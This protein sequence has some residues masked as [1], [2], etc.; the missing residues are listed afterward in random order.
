M[1]RDLHYPCA[2]NH[3]CNET[4]VF[5]ALSGM[6]LVV[7]PFTRFH[8]SNIGTALLGHCLARAANLSYADLLQQ[9]YLTPIHMDGTMKIDN[10]TLA[11][12]AVGVNNG[13]PAQVEEL[14][15]E[16]PCGGL[17]TSANGMATYLSHLFRTDR[18]VGDGQALDGTT[19]SES[20]S[21]QTL[22]RDGR[23]FSANALHTDS[24]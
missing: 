19:V 22:L 20:L 2:F 3:K 11:K 7:P 14:G 23:C 16:S 18:P 12:M 24:S 9:Y 17:L 15:W 13:K 4:D 5:A 10:A 8:Y 6:H 21:A 1:P